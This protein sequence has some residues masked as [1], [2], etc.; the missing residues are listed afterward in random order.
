[1]IINLL[2]GPYLFEYYSLVILLTLGFSLGFF[3]KSFRPAQKYLGWL[4]IL[5]PIGYFYWTIDLHILD[6]P[7]VDD[8]D[9]LQ[10]ILDMTSNIPFIDKVKA[11]FSQINQHRFA[12]ERIVMWLILVVNGAENITLQ[13][14]VG[15]ALLIGILYLFFLI[16]EREGISWHFLI[17]VSFMLFNL[18]YYENANW[19]IA[20]IQ[21]T[22]LLFFALLSAY[23]L[24]SENN[25]SW[26]LALIT[27]LI[28]SFTSGSGLLT[29][30]IGAAILIFQKKY[31]KLSIWLASA[32]AVFLFYF[33][34]DYQI[35]HSGNQSPLNHPVYN[36][37]FLLA[38]WGN[39]LYLDKQHPVISGNYYDIAACVALGIGIGLVFCAWLV[40]IVRYNTSMRTTSFITGSLMFTMG[41]GAM[42]VLSRPIDYY[43][44]YGGELF[45]RRYMIFGVVLL[46]AAYIALLIMTKNTK[47]LAGFLGITGMVFA[48]GLNFFSYFASISKV[49]KQYETLSLDGHYWRNY[50]MA[51]SFG[52][53]FGEK[54]FW[55]HPT[56]MT[57]LI[58]NLE[59][60]NIYKLPETVLPV[61]SNQI[62]S[63]L[64]KPIAFDGKF[65]SSTEIRDNFWLGKPSDFIQ[66]AYSEAPESTF[67]PVYFQLKSAN[68]L[69][70]L[71]AYPLANKWGDFLVR[72]TYYSNNY[73]YSFFADK[74]LPGSYEVWVVGKG[75]SDEKGMWKSKFT[76]KTVQL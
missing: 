73:E 40:R 8:Y 17:P 29:W 7:F 6:V 61:V 75:S 41:T 44:T 62:T 11:L 53:R 55:N 57:S 5:L 38:F 12:Y 10:S 69:F 66:L 51:M 48:L 18:V 32:A 54:L 45:S 49:R 28:A 30:F 52:N 36:L 21:N 33:L 24:G 9:L 20:A 47:R 50:G 26:Y 42:L 70:I 1:L 59:T 22:S 46:I 58:R 34:F 64:A 67:T 19:G 14:I 39:V 13:I 43:V 65:T 15:D 63:T 16:F 27:A 35:I 76:G 25:R 31:K 68:H 72:H 3:L 60:S 56:R 2:P 23:A 37:S 4:L 71:P 74:F